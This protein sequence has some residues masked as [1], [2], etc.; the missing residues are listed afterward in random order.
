MRLY[1]GSMW[2]IRGNKRV[3]I[4]GDPWIPDVHSTLDPS[5]SLSLNLQTATVDW[6]IDHHSYNGLAH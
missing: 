3:K 2:H 6:L 5:I 4:L 1:K